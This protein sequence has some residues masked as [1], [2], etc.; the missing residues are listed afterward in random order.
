MWTSVGR[1]E[2]FARR[3]AALHE[4]AKEY[5]ADVRMPW[6][7]FWITVPN[8]LCGLEW[9]IVLESRDGLFKMLAKVDSV[10]H[11]PH[12]CIHAYPVFSH[13]ELIASV[14]E[15]ALQSRS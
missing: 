4:G 2:P 15:H 1:D 9:I 7:C 13:R 5:V 8:N 6:R 14:C 12:G 10:T 11:P 3:I